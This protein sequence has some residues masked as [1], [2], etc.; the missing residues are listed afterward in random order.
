MFLLVEDDRKAS[1]VLKR[2]PQ[3]EG[4]VVDPASGRIRPESG[5]GAGSRFAISGPAAG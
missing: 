5:P 4:F 3:E 1:R 2:G